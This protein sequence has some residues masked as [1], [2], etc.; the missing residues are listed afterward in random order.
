MSA[1]D[2]RQTRGF[3]WNAGGWFGSQIGM[4]AWILVTA[5]VLYPVDVVLPDANPWDNIEIMLNKWRNVGSY[6]IEIK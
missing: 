4:T 2:G 6:P 1:Q 5:F 3:R